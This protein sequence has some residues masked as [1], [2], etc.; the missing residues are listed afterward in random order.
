MVKCRCSSRPG[1]CGAGRNSSAQA[2]PASY[3]EFTFQAEA[4][5]PY[6]L[7]IRGKAERNNWAN[8]SAFVQ[9]SGT[10]DGGGA[11][12]FRIGTTDAAIYQV[13][14]GVNAGLSN[15]GW[16]DHSYGELADPIYFATTGTQT[17]R[18]QPRED[19]ISIDQIVI[20]AGT[21]FD[22]RP[23]LTKND[24]TIVAK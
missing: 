11:P 12:T 13:E 18:L 10:V 20:S 7:W 21:Y 9:F 5:R 16:Q 8:D 15:W 17:I 23:G 1:V 22:V 3:V 6:R 14:E 4:G 19:G 24:A 2:A